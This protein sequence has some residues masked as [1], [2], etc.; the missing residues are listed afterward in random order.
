MCGQPVAC[1]RSAFL[2]GS[3]ITDLEDVPVSSRVRNFRVGRNI[4]PPTRV[5][6]IWMSFGELGFT[7]HHGPHCDYRGVDIPDLV[8]AHKIPGDEPTHGNQN[9]REYREP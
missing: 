5:A 8:Q 4:K 1:V 2:L 7:G 6:E 9:Q 3:T